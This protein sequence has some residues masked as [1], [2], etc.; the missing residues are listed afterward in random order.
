MVNGLKAIKINKNKLKVIVYA[1]EFESYKISF[2]DFLTSPL[3]AS[4]LIYDILK[5]A[6]SSGFFEADDALSISVTKKSDKIIFFITKLLAPIK[7]FLKEKSYSLFVFSN[8]K[9]FSSFLSSINN[10]IFSNCYL[11]SLNGRLI[12]QVPKENH[13][14]TAALE[15]SDIIASEF[16]CDMILSKARLICNSDGFSSL[17]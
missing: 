7:N 15:F 17:Y 11:Y 5:V 1:N 4:K 3:R 14:C 8:K 6:I 2:S 10:E 13:L 16:V 12:F 9:V